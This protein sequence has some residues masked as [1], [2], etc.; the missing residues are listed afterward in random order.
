MRAGQPTPLEL[1]ALM[2]QQFQ[3]S[4]Y[5]DLLLQL[6]Q[7]TADQLQASASAAA[8]ATVPA[9]NTGSGTSS[10]TVS[11]TQPGNS[12]Q[13]TAAL[14]PKLTEQDWTARPDLLLLRGVLH[15]LCSYVTLS[16]C[17]PRGKFAVELV[18]ACAPAVVQLASISFQRISQLLEQYQLDE[19]S[20][21]LVYEPWVNADEAVRLVLTP[22]V[23]P[24]YTT[25]SSSSSSILDSSGLQQYRGVLFDSSRTGQCMAVMLAVTV[26]TT[27]LLQLPHL[28][29]LPGLSASNSSSCCC[30]G[31]DGSSSSS[32]SS[33]G[34]GINSSTSS[35]SS[36]GGTK[37]KPTRKLRALQCTDPS[38]AWQ[39]AC[40]QH[41]LLP[42]THQ[43]LLRQVGCSSRA[44]LFAA[45]SMAAKWNASMT[46][47]SQPPVPM[48]GIYRLGMLT[49]I[50]NAFT[51]H[52]ERTWDKQGQQQQQQQQQ[53]QQQEQQRQQQRQQ[54]QQY[55]ISQE[56]R[57]QQL[58][59][60]LMPG[61]L[62]YYAALQ[63]T[64]LPGFRFDAVPAVH[65]SRGAIA[66]AMRLSVTAGISPSTIQAT[67][68][69]RNVRS[70]IPASVRE[71]LLVDV[72]ALATR[73]GARYL[74]SLV[75]ERSDSSTGT[76]NSSSSNS[77][78]TTRTNSSGSSIRAASSSGASSEVE[79]ASGSTG[80]TAAMPVAEHVPTEPVK[81]HDVA[82]Q[83]VYLLTMLALDTE[84]SAAGA[85]GDVGAVQVY[86]PL[87]A[88]VWQ[89]HTIAVA[90]LLEGTVRHNPV[91]NYVL[92]GLIGDY[93]PGPIAAGARAAGPGSPEQQQLISLLRSTLKALAVPSE[94]RADLQVDKRLCIVGAA[95]AAMSESDAAAAA[96]NTLAVAAVPWLA[97]MG[98]C[99]LLLAALLPEV[100]TPP[101]EGQ[102]RLRV[103]LV[104]PAGTS[105]DMQNVWLFMLIKN[106]QHIAVALHGLL[107]KNGPTNLKAQL[108]QAGYS[109]WAAIPAQLQ[110]MVDAAG[111]LVMPDGSAPS[112]D[113]V[114][115]AAE[116]MTT[117]G[118]SLNSL[119]FPTACNNPRCSNLSGPSEL[120][121]VSGRGKMC[122]G[123]LVA[124]Y[125]S[126][127]CQ[128]QHWKQHKPVCKALAAAAAKTANADSAAAAAAVA[129]AK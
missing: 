53:E 6:L 68:S 16:F 33:G 17:W 9:S 42:P 15:L 95:T 23:D 30:S 39:F 8:S 97:I 55:S 34:G 24:S 45:V 4:G 85:A 25:Q 114:S 63:H 121:L 72:L 111:A 64:S 118:L 123:C 128:R 78:R 36:A 32:K 19:F 21:T 52:C 116:L 109:S 28:P 49:S 100:R 91:L 101:A 59:L 82:L 104:G 26:Y 71:A 75:A 44:V 129:A 96:S 67:S 106:V 37:V 99:L 57:H 14:L 46:P 20:H 40:E 3:Q 80:G 88:A 66:A 81:A 83:L 102:P 86:A 126:R 31:N 65:S 87:S 74:A 10:S 69:Y 107:S 5:L 29:D 51:A 47:A 48:R 89:Q 125:C 90:Q 13:D 127:D 84:F 50:Y 98:R 112:Q 62:L 94:E 58:L 41:Q 122:A 108:N 79:Q 43:E 93:G 113:Q 76:N 92:L 56:Q 115:T 110:P 54:Q 117:L 77:D 103:Q 119:A 73:I 12:K 27:L 124:R 7:D 38:K 60:C 1:V 70:F 120:L 35:T 11:P 105:T 18:P 22:D 61:V 2:G